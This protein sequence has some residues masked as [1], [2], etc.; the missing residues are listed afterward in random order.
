MDKNKLLSKLISNFTWNFEYYDVT[1]EVGNDSYVK[2]FVHLYYRSYPR[3]ILSTN[4]EKNGGTL[5]HIK[6]PNIFIQD[7]SSNLKV[8]KRE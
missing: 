6:L 8:G 2:H 5:T 7:F 4:K 3:R 1:I